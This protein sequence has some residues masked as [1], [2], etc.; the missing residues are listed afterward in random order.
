MTD[1][2]LL[3]I[4]GHSLAFR[5]FYATKPEAF[6]TS[7]GQC[8][9]AVHGFISMLV[10]LVR[11]EKPT[12]LAV[13]FDESHQ[14]FRLEEYPDYKGGRPPTPELFKGQITFIKEFLSAANIVH[15]AVSSYE[16][17]DIVATLSVAGTRAGMK[18]LICSG[19]RDAIQLVNDQVTLLYPVKG[20][21]KMTRFTPEVV[22]ET[23][24]VPPHRYPELAALVGES[25]DNL[26]GVHKVGPKTAVKWINQYDGLDNILA[27]ADSIAGQV[28]ENLRAS[29]DLVKR[30]R[31]LN[32]LVT[33]LDLPVGID[34]CELRPIDPD[35]V[36]ELMASLEFTNLRKRFFSTWPIVRPV[37]GVPE[38]KEIRPIEAELEELAPGELA[39]W[40]AKHLSDS[41]VG[42]RFLTK[43]EPGGGE[44]E[45]VLIAVDGRVCYVDVVDLSVDDERALAAWLA[46]PNKPKI[47]HDLKP[48][49]LCLWDRGWILDGV[50]CDSELVAYLLEPS[51]KSYAVDDL[52]KKYLFVSITEAEKKKKTRKK[53]DQMPVMVEDPQ[54]RRKRLTIEAERT[55][56]TRRL[57]QQ[58]PE[59]LSQGAMELLNEVEMPLQHIL[60]SMERTG[61]AV[62]HDYLDTMR[63]Q[64][65]QAAAQA[66]QQAIDILGEKV[67]LDS[68]L[69][70]QEVLFERLKMP[71]TRKIAKGYSTDAESLTEL[72]ATTQHPFLES[73]LIYRDQ[74]KLSQI[75]TGLIKAV[76]DDGRIHTSFMQTT[77]STGR[78]SSKNPNLQ[79]IPAR[80]EL[81]RQIR[82]AFIPGDGYESLLSADYSQIEMRVMTDVCQDQD[83]IEAFRSGEDFHTEMAARVFGV[84][85]AQVSSD[86]RSKIKAMNYG[87]AYGLS[88]FGLAKQLGITNTEAKQLME[89]YFSRF[90]KVHDYLDGVV[91]K[92]RR[93]GYTETI[94]GRRRYLPDLVSDQRR[95]RQ[96]AERAALNAPIQ[97][98]AADIMKVAM[99]KVFDQMAAQS[100]RSRILLQ[101]HDELIIEVAPGE[102]NAVRE[103]VV[104]VMSHAITMVVPLDVSVGV[105]KTWNQAQ[106]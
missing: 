50:V 22:E 52:A 55:E 8:T 100:L 61:I 65:D 3:L 87:L 44:L 101:V 20:V 96:I 45:A 48:D 98:S 33:D 2:T 9:N 91:A 4:D 78:L 54:E 75:V 24:L 15:L 21:T 35:A 10:K 58:L 57:G 88:V 13:A 79:N 38:Q 76:A 97:G 12:H 59:Q 102:E 42:L 51:E 17:D 6:Q 95:L 53:Q 37:P 46:D 104:D 25:S 1:S 106:H 89:V 60:A 5:A 47:L 68:P 30:N 82:E 26:P 74:N 43:H 83:L 99:I 69:Q 64:F 31:R 80:S 19:D 71:P 18:T 92:A 81:G 67:N 11:E 94:L 93:T 90:G 56:A 63:S 77:T 66:Q 84:D 39:G 7:T 29:I 40:M 105:G 16:A 62:N 27:H 14:T 70:L 72:F 86:Q 103:L 34:D 85:P 36:E 73:L 23:Y 32:R 41:Q 49:L 28:G